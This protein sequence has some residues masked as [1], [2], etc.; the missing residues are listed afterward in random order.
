[1]AEANRDVLQEHT[2]DLVDKLH[3]KLTEESA[4]A[5]L[6]LDYDLDVEARR[7]YASTLSEIALLVGD[8][9]LEYVKA[10]ASHHQSDSWLYVIVVLTKSMVI[11]SAGAV[12]AES[13]SSDHGAVVAIARSALASLEVSA[14]RA[15]PFEGSTWPGTINVLAKYS[16]HETGV[17][18]TVKGAESADALIETLRGDLG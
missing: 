13:T 10:S 16:G 1:M 9:P 11:T 4:F 5:R 12:E 17:V 18:F 7:W 3:E 8:E 14:V 6:A 15:D 2:A